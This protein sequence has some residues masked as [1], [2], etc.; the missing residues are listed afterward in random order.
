M[1][2]KE[3]W[4]LDTALHNG[5]VTALELGG[6]GSHNKLYDPDKEK[7]FIKIKKIRQKYDKELKKK[8]DFLN[9][10]NELDNV[11]DVPYQPSVLVDSIASTLQDSTSMF[12][13]GGE[14][15]KEAEPSMLT[16]SQ[17]CAAVE[18]V[19]K[20]IIKAPEL[21]LDRGPFL[22]L[23]R[24]KSPW[25]RGPTD[26]YSIPKPKDHLLPSQRIE[27]FL[28][29]G[30]K[31]PVAKDFV[32]SKKK[33]SKK[34]GD[35]PLE[36]QKA[37]HSGIKKKNSSRKKI[38]AEGD[39]DSDLMHAD[40]T[41][42]LSA[43]MK[44]VTANLLSGEV[45]V[46]NT[47]K[48]PQAMPVIYCGPDWENHYKNRKKI[49]T[50]STE[51][52]ITKTAVPSVEEYINSLRNR[53]DFEFENKRTYKRV[54]PTR[55]DEERTAEEGSN[56]VSDGVTSSAVEK[57]NSSPR[58]E[59]ISA[60]TDGSASPTVENKNS[61]PREVDNSERDRMLSPG[62]KNEIKDNLNSLDDEVYVKQGDDEDDVEA[63]NSEFDRQQLI[64]MESEELF[65][66]NQDIPDDE[67][68]F[69][70]ARGSSASP[71]NRDTDDEVERYDSTIPYGD[72]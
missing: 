61:P 7:E 18:S 53:S 55:K 1:Y 40:T 10:V 45:V 28:K 58:G 21:V 2:C 14:E 38:K 13:G 5:T 64:D 72:D 43:E 66:E 24:P 54:S 41:P 19:A 68:S 65:R 3:K 9:F 27:Q 51:I 36:E 31:V 62:D 11:P 50:E 32:F 47:R 70:D 69:D 37:N 6:R 48:A 42:A 49:S 67:Q 8:H 29:P 33:G 30:S 56:A 60:I 63:S 46:D 25:G 4:D 15:S 17:S 23:T 34:T 39:D 22:D 44:A 59:D 71:H 35:F 52:E 20:Q 26:N 16:S 57:R 12:E